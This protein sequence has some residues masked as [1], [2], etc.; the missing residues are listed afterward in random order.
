MRPA[1]FVSI[2]TLALGVSIALS[3]S[4]VWNHCG[5]D[6]GIF[7]VSGGLPAVA[8]VPVGLFLSLV[9]ALYLLIRVMRWFAGGT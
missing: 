1:A 5:Y 8:T 6:C 3:G 9:S 7:T 2:A 4:Y